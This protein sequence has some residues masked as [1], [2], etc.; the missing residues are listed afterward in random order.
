MAAAHPAE[1][2]QY[3]RLI[4]QALTRRNEE[5]ALIH[6]ERQYTYRQARSLVSRIA[7]VFEARGVAG[8]AVGALSTNS[9]EVYLTDLASMLTG[10][11]WTGLHPLGTPE[12]Q[13]AI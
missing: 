7:Q 3:C 9:P 13:A 10:S 1:R 4:Q 2:S 11:R 6:G 12:T 8:S 5:I